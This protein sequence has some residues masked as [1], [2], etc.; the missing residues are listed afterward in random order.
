MK[1]VE[2]HSLLSGHA[3]VLLERMESKEYFSRLLRVC[4]TTSA[5]KQSE[6]SKVMLREVVKGMDV[7][8]SME[9]YRVCLEYLMENRGEIESFTE[10]L[11][12]EEYVSSLHEQY[13]LSRVEPRMMLYNMVQVLGQKVF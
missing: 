13:Q 11:G 8:E 10:C 1:D 2:R 5:L 3:L 9:E 4:V 6:E 12:S 7:V